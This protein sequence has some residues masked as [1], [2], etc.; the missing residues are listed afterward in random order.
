MFCPYCG[1]QTPADAGSCQ[2]CGMHIEAGFRSKF[3]ATVVSHE[4][5]PPPQQPATPAGPKFG[6]LLVF[7]VVFVAFI[8]VFMTIT[9]QMDR[10]GGKKETGTAVPGNDGSVS[11][12]DASA[13]LL[14][15][16]LEV[17]VTNAAEPA[18]YRIAVVTGRKLSDA[19][20]QLLFRIV[21]ERASRIIDPLLASGKFRGDGEFL[22][23]L[24]LKS[25]QNEADPGDSSG[26]ARGI[27][28][29]RFDRFELPPASGAAADKPGVTPGQPD[30]KEQPEQN[31]DPVE[32]D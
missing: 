27:R 3:Q 28:A 6:K 29:L 5:P 2:H 23:Q 16:L 11:E 12:P 20:Q 24:L 31:S 32:S 1:R 25:L 21:R 7:I 10:R 9:V 30:G 19:E 14:T 18:R 8:G 17:S 15:P 22:L 26:V 4:P 13:A